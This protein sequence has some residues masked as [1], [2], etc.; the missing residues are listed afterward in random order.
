MKLPTPLRLSAVPSNL[1]ALVE[2]IKIDAATASAFKLAADADGWIVW[3][4]YLLK[5]WIFDLTSYE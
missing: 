4:I 3:K 2:A 1:A 5:N